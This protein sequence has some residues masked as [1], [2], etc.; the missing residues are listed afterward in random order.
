M[1]PRLPLF[2]ALSLVACTESNA[3]QLRIRVP[4]AGG[5]EVKAPVEYLGVTIGQVT[6][7]RFVEDG[8]ELEARLLR[9]DIPLRTGDSVQIAASSFFGDKAVFI[10]PGPPN[11]PLLQ[12]GGVLRGRALLP[13]AAGRDSFVAALRSRLADSAVAGP[14]QRSAGE[15]VAAP[16]NAP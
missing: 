14:T 16:D 12:S 6:A 13:S 1:I 10:F 5:I 15:P 3:P 9:S 4:D 8:V 7:V 11:A 2:A